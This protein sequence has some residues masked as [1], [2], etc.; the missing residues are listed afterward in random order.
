MNSGEN[1]VG[2]DWGDD[3]LQQLIQVEQL[4]LSSQQQQQ[5]QQQEP[6]TFVSYS[7]PRELSQRP[8]IHSFD[9]SPTR[10]LFKSAPSPNDSS[11]DLEIQRL[12][13]WLNSFSPFFIFCF[14]YC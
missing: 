8:A 3:F 6:P 14:L 11:K 13:V 9:P 1:E 12:K 2:D 7:P 5:Q 10:V 4:A